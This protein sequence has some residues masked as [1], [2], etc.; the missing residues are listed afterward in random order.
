MTTP[1]RG[2][3]ALTAAVTLSIVLAACGDE[4]TTDTAG[5]SAPADQPTAAEQVE[6][7]DNE[8]D[9]MFA[10]GM[11]PHHRQ[12]VAMS[13][14][15]LDRAED[16]EVVALAEEISTA[17]EPEIQTMTAFLEAWDAEVP[18]DDLSMDDMAMEGMDQEGT[19]PEGMAGMMSPEDMA[20]LESAQGAKF[21]QMFLQMMIEHHEGAVSMAETEVDEGEN[22]A[23]LDLAQTIIVTQES[24]IERMQGLLGS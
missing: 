5:G 10:Q 18:T 11:I 20:E 2:A 14:L 24:E 17:Q 19:G 4:A 22:P 21:D 15:A 8:A 6:G 13:E 3:A 7:S 16:P 23:A 1:L 12:A 9:V